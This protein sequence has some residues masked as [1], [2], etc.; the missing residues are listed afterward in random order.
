MNTF[1]LPVKSPVNFFFRGPTHSR[2]ETWWIWAQWV[3]SKEL[4]RHEMG[5]P[6]SGQHIGPP[7][8]LSCQ[9]VVGTK[10]SIVLTAGGCVHFPPPFRKHGVLDDSPAKNQATLWF[11]PWLHFGVRNGFRPP[12]GFNRGIKGALPIGES[13]PARPLESL[14][15]V[16]AWAPGS[17]RRAGAVGGAW[18]SRSVAGVEAFPGKWIS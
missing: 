13:R 4:T 18:A 9:A 15:R 17:P 3:P 10:P 11:Q 14:A 5:H 16:W 7:R 6:H 8:S 1:L 12:T 2:S